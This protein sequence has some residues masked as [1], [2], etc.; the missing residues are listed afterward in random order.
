MSAISEEFYVKTVLTDVLFESEPY[1]F[2]STHLPLL[3]CP[4]S[5]FLYLSFGFAHSIYLEHIFVKSLKTD[6]KKFFQA[7]KLYDRPIFQ[8]VFRAVPTTAFRLFSIAALYVKSF[9]GI[10]RNATQN[11]AQRGI[12]IKMYLTI[13]VD[14]STV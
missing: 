1:R 3:S 2:H 13:I 7:E 8:C 11:S 12:E 10:Y 9:A 6:F 14:V 5:E 4:S